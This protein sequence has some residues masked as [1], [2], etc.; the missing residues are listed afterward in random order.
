MVYKNLTTFNVSS[1][2]LTAESDSAMTW[3]W[4]AQNVA[5][6]DHISRVCLKSQFAFGQGRSHNHNF[7]E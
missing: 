5:V 4:E 3:V 7:F 6:F 1:H 2:I